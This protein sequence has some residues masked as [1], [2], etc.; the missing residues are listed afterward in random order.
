MRG[1]HVWT[2]R[3]RCSRPQLPRF[4][5]AL[6]VLFGLAGALASFRSAL[7]RDGGD[8]V[9]PPSVAFPDPP[10]PPADPSLPPLPPLE[11]EL[12]YARGSFLYQPEGDRLG[13]DPE[14]AG[15]R[16]PEDFVG[17]Q[18]I[19]A[20][21]PFLGPGP[22]H[23]RGKWF[24]AAG[25]AWEPRFVLAGEYRL[26]A[27]GFRENGDDFLAAGH[28]LILDFDLQLTGTERFHVQWRPLGKRA[29]G[30]SYYTFSQPTGYTDNSTAEPDRYWFEGEVGSIFGGW[31][32]PTRAWDWNVSAGKM[33]LA[34]H[35]RL[36]LNDEVLG[37]VVSK[38]NLLFGNFSNINIEAFYLFNDVD[39]DLD[40]NGRVAGL[41][42]LADRRHAFYEATYAFWHKPGQD[43]MHFTGFSRTQFYGL[44]TVA[45]RALFK[46]APQRLD[47]A[48]Q[49][50]VLEV[51]RELSHRPWWFDWKPAVAYLNAF[52]ATKGW[53][54]LGGAN[55]NRL[56]TAFEVNPIVRIAAGLAPEDRTGLV[57]GTQLFRRDEDESLTTELAWESREGTSVFGAGLRYQRKLTVRTWWELLAL[58]N[59]SP[60]SRYDRI[61][62]LA[63]WFFLW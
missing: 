32:D 6:V 29:T 18:P 4:R 23:L 9:P 17:P 21:A 19:W 1:H 30:G 46:F 61:G 59:T 25:Y 47:G 53:R 38:N 16:L 39:F 31:L 62:A 40:T 51:T 37:L 52:R 3:T 45:L 35:N 60:D 48:G 11:E 24:G 12:G 10:P 55:F 26:F 44:Y 49:F 13:A 33:P 50:F 2:R 56:E 57:L 15:L 42:V 28:H 43:A 54:S 36:L 41:H 7:S 34:F 5:L 20:F 14:A 8:L 58:A 63:T 22:I 27:L